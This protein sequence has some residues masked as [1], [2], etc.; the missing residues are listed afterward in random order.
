MSMLT[1]PSACEENIEEWTNIEND[2]RKLVSHFF[3][4]HNNLWIHIKLFT[5]M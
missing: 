2:L 4:I 1:I 3:A 5:N